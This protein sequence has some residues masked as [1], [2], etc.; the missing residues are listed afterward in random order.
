MTIILKVCQLKICGGR[1]AG[2][3]GMRGE[4]SEEKEREGEDGD[5]SQC[6]ERQF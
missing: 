3:I 5:E 4:D 6:R 1:V 2:L